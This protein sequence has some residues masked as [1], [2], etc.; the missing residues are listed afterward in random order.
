MIHTYRRTLVIAGIIFYLFSIVYAYSGGDGTAENPYQ[1]ATV[2]DWQQLMYTSA[3]WNQ[4]FLMTADVNLQGV[5]LIPIGYDSGYEDFMPF[6]GVFDGNGHIVRNAH[7]YEPDS[8]M[9][10]L[11]GVFVDGII[12][13]L[14]AEDVNIIGRDKVGGLVGLKAL[15]CAIEN[16]YVT[17]TVNGNDSAGGLAGDNSNGPITACHSECTVSG[18]SNIG[19]LTGWNTGGNISG[20]YSTGQVSGNGNIGG[21]IGCNDG[22]V[23]DCY[24]LGAIK[25]DYFGAG[26]LIGLSFNGGT[27][28]DCYA[29]GAVDGNIQAGGL[30]G[31]NQEPVARCFAWGA[32]SGDSEVGGLI[33]LN[34]SNITNSY[35]IGSVNANVFA[36]GLAGYNY[37]CNITNCYSTGTVSGDV[38]AGGLTGMNDNGNI[39]RCY[40]NGI[41][42]GNSCIGGLAGYNYKSNI[43]KCHTG[44]ILTGN[45]FVGGLAGSNCDSNVTDCYFAGSV[46]GVSY[47]GGLC[48]IN[49]NGGSLCESYSIGDVNGNIY[50]GGLAGYNN[51][52]G[53]IS[54]C[55]STGF[56]SGTDYVGGLAGINDGNVTA[57]FWDVNTSGQATSAGGE[58]KTTEEMQDIDTY[59]N[60]GWDFSYTDGNP[61]DWFIQIDEYP[62]LVWQISPADIYTDGRNNFRDFAIFSQYWMR[63]DCRVYN[64]YCDWSDLDFDGDVDI[65]DLIELMNYWLETGI[66]D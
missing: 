36:G 9:V 50:I 26:G 4:C 53:S 38:Y 59:V 8:N 42:T 2:S 58:G 21:L 34:V 20:C 46:N 57:C 6:L 29:K 60:A 48:G 11:F 13:N 5:T 7:I 27:I 44:G 64:D 41:V 47:A 52:D 61:A 10:G 24:A 49:Y 30:I 23:S 22:N 12:R 43:S 31:E 65:Y 18:F 40:S 63:E 16:C 32:V 54:N 25:G 19:G 39:Q 62:I 66:Y 33:G 37:F 28:T 45:G 56:V 15:D 3:D 14:G 55:Y 1:I 17:G 51:D 35:A